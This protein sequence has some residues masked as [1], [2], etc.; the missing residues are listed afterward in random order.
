MGKN[1]IDPITHILPSAFDI[2]MGE[3]LYSERHIANIFAE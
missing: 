2:P 1:K 3:K